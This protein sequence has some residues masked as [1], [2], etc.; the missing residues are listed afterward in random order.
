MAASTLQSSWEYQWLLEVNLVPVSSDAWLQFDRG[1]K[2]LFTLIVS[3][4][5]RIQ[6]FNVLISVQIINITQY[7]L[8]VGTNL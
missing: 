8:S 1:Q 6:E 2:V 4:Q 3:L 7:S 5:L